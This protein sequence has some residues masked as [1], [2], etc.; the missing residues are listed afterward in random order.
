MRRLLTCKLGLTTNSHVSCL[1]CIGHRA[2]SRTRHPAQ[3]A[4]L[5]GT[6]ATSTLTQNANQLLFAQSQ[7]KNVCCRVLIRRV[8]YC[9]CNAC[10]SCLFWRHGCAAGSSSWVD[11][12]NW[13]Y[14]HPAGECL[15]CPPIQP[16]PSASSQPAHSQALG[17]HPTTARLLDLRRSQ[18]CCADKH[19]AGK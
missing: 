6:S 8:G 15:T 7:A 5:L 13:R 12:C 17:R 16:M 3:R 2:G 18:S 14:M 4:L 9:C 11:H 10:P 1:L 19:S